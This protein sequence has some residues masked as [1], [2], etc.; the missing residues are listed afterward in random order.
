M[1]SA[2]SELYRVFKPYRL[3]DDFIGCDHCVTQE[4]S[5][6]LASISLRKLTVP[7]VDRYAFKAMSTW[8]TERHFKH[9]LPRLLELAYEDYQA[10][11]FPEVLLGK[12]A[13]AD[14]IRGLRLNEKQSTTSLTVFGCTSFTHPVISRTTNS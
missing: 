4:D 5:K 12:L 2:I 14:G 9:F 8:G 1:Q 13:Y 6:L 10:F 7:D 3:D 11:N